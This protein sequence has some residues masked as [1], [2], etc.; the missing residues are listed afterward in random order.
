M[1]EVMDRRWNRLLV[2]RVVGRNKKCSVSKKW[3]SLK[4]ID[5]RDKVQED[6]IFRSCLKEP[7]NY[8]NIQI[9][10]R[11]S[12]KQY[13]MQKLRGKPTT[14]VLLYEKLCYFTILRRTV[15]RT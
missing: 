12:K 13:F 8:F 6:L 3:G 1:R 5:S 2:L 11:E 14:F 7:E 4:M 15:G 10:S 9:G